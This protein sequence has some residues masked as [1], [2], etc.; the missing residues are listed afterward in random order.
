MVHF[1]KAR[2][3][4]VEPMVVDN[5]SPL[6]KVSWLLCDNLIPLH[7]QIRF[8]ASFQRRGWSLAPHVN[9]WKLQ[10]QSGG[11]DFETF[12]LLL[13]LLHAPIRRRV[14]KLCV[15]LGLKE[16]IAADSCD[17]VLHKLLLFLGSCLRQLYLFDL[18]LDLF[19]YL[20]RLFVNN[21]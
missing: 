20:W 14:L 8:V 17:K 6:L 5:E 3:D 1:G 9:I 7:G 18:L 12:I 4:P 13:E 10:T 16:H 21:F 19:L 2:V 11:L 15:F